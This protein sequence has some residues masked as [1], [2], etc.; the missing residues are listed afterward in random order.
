MIDEHLE[1]S[2]LAWNYHAVRKFLREAPSLIAAAPEGGDTLTSNLNSGT[3]AATGRKSPARTAQQTIT[4]VLRSA[5][6]IAVLRGYVEPELTRTSMIAGY[7]GPLGI[8]WQPYD[9]EIPDPLP[10]VDPTTRP[11]FTI[12]LGLPGAGR[13]TSVL[14]EAIDR[15]YAGHKVL[16]LHNS[17][18]LENGSYDV[19]QMQQELHEIREKMGQPAGFGDKDKPDVEIMVPLTP[20]LE[21]TD[22]L[23]DT[24]N[25]EYRVTPFVI[26]TSGPEESMVKAM[27]D[28]GPRLHGA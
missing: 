5:E 17:K 16:D 24:E 26:P 14:K 11:A 3:Y 10:I 20:E 18:K 19:E 13:S 7:S 23:Y 21:D 22:I 9:W 12:S 1:G 6:S 15:Y 25:S 28:P 4:D 2:V 27:L 8:M